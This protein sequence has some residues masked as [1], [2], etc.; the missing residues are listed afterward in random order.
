MTGEGSPP[1]MLLSP[2]GNLSRTSILYCYYNSIFYLSD[3][4]TEFSLVGTL[5]FTYHAFPI[6][7]LIS[8]N[9]CVIRQLQ[10][11]PILLS[12]YLISIDPEKH[13]NGCLSK[14]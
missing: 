6:A 4:G 2:F 10:Q 12:Y 7:S 13:S 11:L 14:S 9:N 3:I 1:G 8:L 5:F